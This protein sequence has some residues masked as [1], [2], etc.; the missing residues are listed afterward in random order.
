MDNTET[1]GI[2]I[3]VSYFL[4]WSR[5]CL[6]FGC[7]CVH[8]YLVCV[9]ELPHFVVSV[10]AYCVLFL[11]FHDC[12][13]V[14]FVCVPM[15]KVL[16]MCFCVP[17]QCLSFLVP[18]HCVWSN[19]LCTRFWVPI[20]CVC[21][22]CFHTRRVLLNKWNNLVGITSLLLQCHPGKNNPMILRLMF[23]T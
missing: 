9:S 21:F 13:S 6:G 17:V 8:M 16:G 5:M 2:L 7:S 20:L 10:F 11:C 4:C 14:Y 15:L 18:V 22:L 12:V 19:V 1:L 3:S 23:T